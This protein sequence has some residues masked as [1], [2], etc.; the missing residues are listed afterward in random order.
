MQ[1]RIYYFK[2]DSKYMKTF[3]VTQI[4]VTIYIVHSIY[5]YTHKYIYIYIYIYTHICTQVCI[6]LGFVFQYWK[7]KQEIIIGWI[8]ICFCFSFL[9]VLILT[10]PVSYHTYIF[11]INEINYVSCLLSYFFMWSDCSTS[12]HF[13]LSDISATK[14]LLWFLRVF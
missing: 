8:D 3:N 4:A 6:Y 12:A 5:I 10:I 9:I 14:Y 1:C 11:L 13:L 7:V 2:V